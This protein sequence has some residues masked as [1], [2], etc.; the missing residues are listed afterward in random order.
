MVDAEAYG[1]SD[2]KNSFNFQHFDLRNLRLT[3]NGKAHP[4]EGVDSDFGANVTSS[5]KTAHG[6]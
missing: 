1:G 5:N 2:T 3:M 4:F 6:F